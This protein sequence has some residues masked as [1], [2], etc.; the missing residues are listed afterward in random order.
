[1]R[2]HPSSTYRERSEDDFWVVGYFDFSSLLLG[3]WHENNLK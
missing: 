2:D 3:I 1:M